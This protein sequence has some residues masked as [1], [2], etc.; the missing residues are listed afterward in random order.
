ML[1]DA[2]VMVILPSDPAVSV[3][4]TSP[5]ETVAIAVLLEVHVATV[6]MSTVPLQVTALAVKDA[7]GE[8][9]VRLPLV[10]EIVIDWIQPTVTVNDC[11][12]VIEGLSLDVAVTV[13]EPVA[14]EVTNPL[15][16]IVAVVVGLMVQLTDGLPVLP[17]L[18]VPTA[19]ICTVLFVLPVSMVGVAGPTDRDDNV[20]FTKNPRQLAASAN[21]ASAA[22][23][24]I[25]RSFCFLD[26]I[27]V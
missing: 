26:D 13:A 1:P 15:L 17:S 24:P 19:N 23:A 5:A 6:V 14:T 27:F 10:G 21:V 25:S 11:V 4:A 18:K 12:P 16:L 22:K 9:W 7:V 2:A 20:G 3:A 8:A